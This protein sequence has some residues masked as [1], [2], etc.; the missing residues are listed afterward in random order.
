MKPRRRAWRYVYAAHDVSVPPRCIKEIVHGKRAITADAAL[1]RRQLTMRA[2]D[3][4]L[5][6]SL[7]SRFI[8]NARGR[9]QR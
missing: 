8:C 9:S 4:R 7:R 3:R 2:A 5:G 6:S 1:R